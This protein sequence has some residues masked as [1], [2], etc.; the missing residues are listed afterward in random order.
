MNITD[1]AR[2][3]ARE[4]VKAQA[5]YDATPKEERALRAVLLSRV[6]SWSNALAEEVAPQLAKEIQLAVPVAAGANDRPRRR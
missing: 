5:E 4:Y 1:D 6:L 3:Y 2:S